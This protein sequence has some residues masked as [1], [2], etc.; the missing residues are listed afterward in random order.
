[1]GTNPNAVVVI[2]GLIEEYIDITN[3]LQMEESTDLMNRRQNVLDNVSTM[4]VEYVNRFYKET[5][6]T[7]VWIDSDKYWGEESIER[8]KLYLR[9]KRV[10]KQEEEAACPHC[11]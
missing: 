10:Q 2:C 5:G 6:A 1:M 11:S 7:P 3:R 8:V 9:K 4:D